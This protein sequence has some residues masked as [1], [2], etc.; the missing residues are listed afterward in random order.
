MDKI[1]FIESK[2][3]KNLKLRRIEEQDLELLRLWKNINKKSFFY[4]KEISKEEQNMIMS[5]AEDPENWA[6]KLNIKND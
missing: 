1:Q 3:I 6:K 2:E 5:F 4:Q